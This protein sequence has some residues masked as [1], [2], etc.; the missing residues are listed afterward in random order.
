[1][2]YNCYYTMLGP[3]SSSDPSLFH[4]S[5]VSVS[6]ATPF[7][8]GQSTASSGNVAWIVIIKAYR[9]LKLSRNIKN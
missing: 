2:V 5:S 1:M 9:G 8:L 6:T 3:S 4:S 7:S